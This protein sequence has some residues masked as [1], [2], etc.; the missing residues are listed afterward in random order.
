MANIIIKGK[1]K[2]GYS[3]S[4]QE[5]NLRKEGMSTLTDAQLDYLKH[6]EKKQ[7]DTFGL[8]E[9][10]ISQTDIGGEPIKTKDE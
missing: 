6:I 8:K 4:E 9:S 3:R 2:F 7:K 5:Q 10:F 1:T